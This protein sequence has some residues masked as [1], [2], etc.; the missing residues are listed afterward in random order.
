ML[1][2]KKVFYNNQNKIKQHFMNNFVLFFYNLNI[3]NLSR[4]TFFNEVVLHVSLKI[5]VC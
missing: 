3:N 2:Y 1:K 5:E 4:N